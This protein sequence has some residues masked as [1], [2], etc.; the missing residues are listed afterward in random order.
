VVVVRY[1]GGIKLGTSGLITAYKEA[2]IDAI[3]QSEI[4]EAFVSNYYELIFTYDELPL[5]MKWS[6]QQKVSFDSQDFDLRC[7]TTFSL[8]ISESEHKMDSLP[9]GVEFEFLHQL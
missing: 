9:R 7:K 3:N 2:T 4:I 5:V 1:S 8:P 6:K